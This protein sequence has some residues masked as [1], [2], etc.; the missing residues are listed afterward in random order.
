MNRLGL[1]H[2][3]GLP[4]ARPCAWTVSSGF[5]ADSPSLLAGLVHGLTD[6]YVQ[7][8]V[9]EKKGPYCT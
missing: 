9:L 1:L 8:S 5:D 3:F 2:V 6:A 4:A 7:P